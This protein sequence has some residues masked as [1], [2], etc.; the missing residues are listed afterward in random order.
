MVEFLL[1][2]AAGAVICVSSQV[3]YNWVKSKTTAAETAVTS[4]VANTISKAL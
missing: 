2:A 1:G 3:V 4:A